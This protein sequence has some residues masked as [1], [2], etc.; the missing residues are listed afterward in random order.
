MWPAPSS[1]GRSHTIL[2][3]A[4]KVLGWLL[5][6]PGDGWQDRWLASGSDTGL[7]WVDD[8][9]AGDPRC[10]DTKHN[11]V[12]VGL[13]FLLLA[14]VIL[15]SYDFLAAYHARALYKYAR[16]VFCPNLFAQADQAAARVD[17]HGRR[18]KEALAV[19][20]KI[21]LHTGRDLDQV[22]EQD[23]FA[24]RAWESRR[25][26][27]AKS[28]V[29]LAWEMLAGIADLGEHGSLREAVR[30][31]QRETAELVDAYGVRAGPIR[32]VLVRY[33]EER[34]S[35]LDYSSFR[36]L[37]GTLAGNFWADIEQHHPEIDTLQLT[38]Q[39]ADA[40]NSG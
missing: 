5:E 28:S 3:G 21:T 34:R 22:T 12:M 11:E 1:Y 19:L 31:G 7:T 15:P 18:R 16:R 6:H 23:L 24:Y 33:L 4:G 13:C 26:G 17:V 29:P 14:R 37:V 25:F 38:D 32:K 30:L 20:S 40:W 39:V 2:R 36:S 35:S 27:Y 10:H 9:T 8:L